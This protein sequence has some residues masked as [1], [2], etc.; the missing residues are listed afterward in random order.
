MNMSNWNINNMNEWEKFNYIMNVI[1]YK[2]NTD[3]YSFSWD[4]LVHRNY[5][6]KYFTSPL[7]DI[8]EI[9]FT[10]DFIWKLTGFLIKQKDWVRDKKSWWNFYEDILSNLDNIVDYIYM[11]IK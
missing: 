1:W 7:V 8:K 3:K 9:I 5:E 4:Y 6:D 10:S 11:L 2:Y